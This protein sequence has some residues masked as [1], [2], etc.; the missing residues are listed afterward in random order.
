MSAGGCAVLTSV[1][2]SVHAWFRP[3][4][5][6]CPSFRQAFC[7]LICSRT[8]S[9]KGANPHLESR[10]NSSQRPCVVISRV[11]VLVV[12]LDQIKLPLNGRGRWV[13]TQS[14]SSAHSLL[15][16]E[17][18]TLNVPSLVCNYHGMH[19]KA[20]VMGPHCVECCLSSCVWPGLR[21][22]KAPQSMK[23]TRD[24]LS[25]LTEPTWREGWRWTVRGHEFSSLAPH[26][27]P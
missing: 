27:G 7:F 8:R 18:V 14:S 13:S 23:S 3:L 17:Y 6:T 11:T 10:P 2:K 19:I 20:T 9:W 24:T 25:N 15:L 5:L 21:D 26:Q 1:V 22:E 16:Y 4:S 12:S